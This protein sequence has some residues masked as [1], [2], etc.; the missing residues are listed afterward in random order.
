MKQSQYEWQVTPEATEAA[1]LLPFLEELHLDSHLAPL[2]WE[3]QVRTKEELHAFFSPSLSSLHDPYLLYDMEK[4]IQRIQSAVENNETILIYGDYDADG[5]TSTTVMK[6]AIELIGGNVSYYLPNRFEDGYGPN[7]DKYRYFIEEEQVQLIVTVDNGVSGHEAI[8]YAKEK[9][10][11]VIVTDHHEMPDTLPE[12]FSIIHPRHPMGNY[13][14]GDLAGVGVAFKVATALLGDIPVESLDLVAIGTIADLVSL[15]NENRTLVKMG[16]DIMKQTE[17][18]GLLALASVSKADLTKASS[19]LI[20]FTLAPRLNAIGRLGD[21]SPGVELLS[22]FDEEEADTLAIFIQQQNTERQK[23]VKE[24]TNEAL[25][26]VRELEPHPIQILIKEGWHEGVLGIVASRIVK[27]TNKPTLVLTSQKDT[28]MVKGSGR[29]IKSVDLFQLLSTVK[30][31]LTSFGGHHMAAGLSFEE[32]KLAPIQSLLDQELVNRGLT[33]EQKEVIAIDGVLEIADIN[34]PFIETLGKLDPFGTDNPVPHFVIQNVAAK[35]MKRIGADNTHLK[36]QL[37][38]KDSS[39]DCI[40]FGQGAQISEFESAKE[41]SVMGQLSVNE[42]NGNKKPQLMLEDYQISDLQCFDFRG[43]HMDDMLEV[44]QHSAFVVFNENNLKQAL[45]ETSSVFH[46]KQLIEEGYAKIN[47]YQDI[48]IVDYPNT[49]EEGYNVF[50]ELTSSRYYFMGQAKEELYLTGMPGR[51]DFGK[52]FKLIA[53][54]TQIDI[55]YKLTDISQFL[56]IKKNTLI[57]MI[58]VFFELGFVTIEDGLMSKVES[59]ITTPLTKSH[60]YQ[61]YLKR[62]EMEKLFV[63]SDIRQVEQWVLQQE[64]SR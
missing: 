47:E 39:L 30:E 33:E 62:I 23:I 36:G 32:S 38:T 20:G 41:F 50:K 26:M 55:R 37:A 21:A 8:A 7:I 4:T 49:E 57:F 2:L 54:Q 13:P 34:V 3:R 18:V 22:T 12:A 42:W 35:N 51:D 19:E 64:E 56:K 24:I 29:S 17:R 10:I 5:I 28:G 43:K 45:P 1:V 27:E 44:A 61:L 48:V 53:K 25:E 40:A 9:G 15:T 52:L 6:E 11:D 16:L 59:P 46:V 63:Y 58:K 31:E 60:E 14:F